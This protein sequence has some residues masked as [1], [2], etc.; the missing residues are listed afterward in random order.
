MLGI[1][2]DVSHMP[3]GQG[4]APE[5]SRATPGIGDSGVEVGAHHDGLCDSLA[6][7][8]VEA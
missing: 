7:D 4:L 1:L 5:A 8:I 3:T 2:S 6:T